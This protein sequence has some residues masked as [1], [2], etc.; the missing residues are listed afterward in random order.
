MTSSF[1]T[2]PSRAW[3]GVALA[4]LLFFGCQCGPGGVSGEDD[5]G[6][7]KVVN[8]DGGAVD[9]GVDAGRGDAGHVFRENF[10]ADPCPPESFGLAELD[11][12]DS[13]ESPDYVFGVCVALHKL[14]VNAQ[15]NAAPAQGVVNLRFSSGSAEGEIERLPDAFGNFDAKVL[16]HR[17]DSLKYHPSGIFP[18]HEGHEEFGVIDLTADQQRTLAVRSWPIRGS[19]SFG[20]LPFTH[21]T[22]P[23]DV[24]FSAVGI[25]PEQS[26]YTSSNAGAYEVSLLEGLFS[27]YLTSP[28]EALGGTQLVNYPINLSVDL[29]GPLNLDIALPT[30]ELEGEVR[31]DGQ[32]L[33]DRKAGPDFQL[34]YVSP[35]A[36]EA[37]VHTYHEGGLPGFHSLVPKNKYSVKLRLESKPDAHLPSMI[38][39]KQVTQEIDLNQNANLNVNLSTFVWEGALTVDGVPV[40][41]QPG[42][43]WTLYMYGFGSIQAPW[44]LLYFDVPMVGAGYSL[45]VFGG[46]Y[47]TAL[48][49][50]D[51]FAP[52][53][54]EGWYLVDEYLVMDKN[55]TRPIDIKTSRYSGRLYVDGQPPPAGEWAGTLMFRSRDN[56]TYT[57]PLRC[58]EDGSF[59][60]R[61]P[62]GLY[63]IYFTINRDTYPEY[64]SGR[65]MVIGA[66]DLTQD[67]HY[68]VQYNTMLVT[69]PLRVG[70]E[71]VKD[72]LQ[73]GDEVG[74]ELQRYGDRAHFTWGFPGGKNN[75]RMRIPAGDYDLT[76]KIERDGIPGVAWGHGPMGIRLMLRPDNADSPDGG[77]D[78]GF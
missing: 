19:V 2:D 9:A 75:Y 58:A 45:N 4:C 72:T 24:S 36:D 35:G 66:V 38:F 48:M 55:L 63:D 27:V 22:F 25:P 40:T 47:Y 37:N 39:N 15:L 8:T 77:A 34:E 5:A 26:V 43:N 30:S 29:T 21:S 16:R 78:A 54:V 50:D 70:G 41:S 28:P 14:D 51:H 10:V 61:V 69:G 73:G 59:Q 13:L 7:R 3:K 67:Q 57:R 1:T 49:I 68:D 62:K 44:S 74:L 32:P 31:I 23:P 6:D 20:G 46:N 18:S 65:V 60:M 56:G 52:D 11:G 12:G 53:L 76:F 71:V 42:Y 17:Y 64:A 33:K